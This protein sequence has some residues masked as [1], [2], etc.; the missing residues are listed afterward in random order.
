MNKFQDELTKSL[1]DYDR[2][3]AVSKPNYR[4]ALE[5]LISRAVDIKALELACECLTTDGPQYWLDK[6]GES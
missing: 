3:Y 1:D 2:A 5:S 6:A 4:K